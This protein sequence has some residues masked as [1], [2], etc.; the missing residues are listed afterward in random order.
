MLGLSDLYDSVQYG[1]ML[2]VDGILSLD[3]VIHVG[4][5]GENQSQG[6]VM[7]LLFVISPW[8]KV[9]IEVD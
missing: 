7:L 4:G 2:F 8:I 6:L 1:A 5:R 3:F 9:S